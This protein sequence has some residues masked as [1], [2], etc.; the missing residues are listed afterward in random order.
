M[1][2]NANSAWQKISGDG[3]YVSYSTL[4]PNLTNG[5][6]S[7]SAPVLMVAD[8]VGYSRLIETDEACTLAAISTLRSQI[9]DPLLAEFGG[10]VVKLMGDGAIVEFSPKNS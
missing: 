2:G 4:A 7:S 6:A 1:I 10:R 9:I 3:R 5:A 8:I